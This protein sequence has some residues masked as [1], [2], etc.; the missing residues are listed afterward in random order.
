VLIKYNE[1][2]YQPKTLLTKFGADLPEYTYIT[3]KGITYKVV[4]W[5]YPTLMSGLNATHSGENITGFS[6]SRYLTVVH[7]I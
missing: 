7:K 4:M 5:F 1:W 2:L 3:C 6:I